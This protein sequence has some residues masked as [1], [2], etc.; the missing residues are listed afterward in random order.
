MKTAFLLLLVV[1]SGCASPP[2][3]THRVVSPSPAYEAGYQQGRADSAKDQYWSL[4][5]RHQP[6][7]F[8]P[9]EG[10]T[11][12]PI[13]VPEHDLHGSRIQPTT[14]NLLITR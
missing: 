1:L 3:Y 6:D 10:V 7:T 5:Y 11:I 2:L 8:G 14:Q 9:I 13:P 12:Y 4:R